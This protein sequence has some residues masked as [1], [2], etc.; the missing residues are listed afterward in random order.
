MSACRV[1]EVVA[2]DHRPVSNKILVLVSCGSEK[3]DRPAAA[4]DLY[5]GSLFR[6]CRRYAERRGDDWIITSA[7]HGLVDPDKVLEPY[8]QKMSTSPE[9]VHQWASWCQAD[10]GVWLRDHPQ[11]LQK[12]QPGI[13]EFTIIVGLRVVCLAGASY[14][15]PLRRFTSMRDILEEPMRGL[16]MGKRM[17]WLKRNT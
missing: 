1:Q 15:D 13:N 2:T 16:G 14:A 3:L 10:F 6:A 11:F 17:G 4:K 5:T 12:P 7:K 9:L 8:E